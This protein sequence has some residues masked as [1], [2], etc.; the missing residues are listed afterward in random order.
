MVIPGTMVVFLATWLYME[1]TPAKDPNAA[2]PL[3]PQFNFGPL[4]KLSGALS[5]MIPGRAQSRPV[6]LSIRTI[7]TL[8]IIGFLTFWNSSSTP[9]SKEETEQ[10]IGLEEPE[11]IYPEILPEL[12]NTTTLLSPFAN[13][14]AYV[15]YNSNARQDRI[16]YAMAYK[17]FFHTVHISIPDYSPKDSDRK[18][19]TNLT[20]DS[21]GNGHVMYQGVAETMR[22]ILEESSEEVFRKRQTNSTSNSTSNALPAPSE[23]GVRPASE[24]DGIMFYH[25]DAWIVSFK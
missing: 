7:F 16:P 2:S 3:P 22:I 6:G 12:Q 8:F 14:M 21:W 17:P 23:N 11:T 13:T 19:Y 24:I 5:S 20:H 18:F 1:G 25:F 15:R 4:S 9:M 10:T